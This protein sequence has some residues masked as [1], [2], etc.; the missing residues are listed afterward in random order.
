MTRS[1]LSRHHRSFKPNWKLPQGAAGN[2]VTAEMIWNGERIK[3]GAM[4]GARQGLH[5]AGSLIIAQA[6]RNAPFRTGRLRA[7]GGW[8]VVGRYRQSGAQMSQLGREMFT[9]PV[10]APTQTYQTGTGGRQH[11]QTLHL[12][13]SVPYAFRQHQEHRTQSQFLTRAVN[14]YAGKVRDILNKR[15]GKEIQK[16]SSARAWRSFNPLPATGPGGHGKWQ[17]YTPNPVK[18]GSDVDYDFPG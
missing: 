16:N 5:D 10:A 13:F 4:K 18:P 6:R 15:I 3:Q 14:H 11:V 7:S 17:T 1:I 12:F 8:R 9:S 2:M